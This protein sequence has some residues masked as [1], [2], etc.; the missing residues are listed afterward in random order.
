MGQ[1]IRANPSWVK[2]HV[3]IQIAGKTATMRTRSRWTQFVCDGAFFRAIHINIVRLFE[4]DGEFISQCEER[5]DGGRYK[6][7]DS[8]SDG[9]CVEMNGVEVVMV[10]A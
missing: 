3:D 10:P 1:I 8:A 6:L 9:I 7:D 2:E 5:I 4:R